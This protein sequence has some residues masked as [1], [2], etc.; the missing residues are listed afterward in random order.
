MSAGRRRQVRAT[1]RRRRPEHKSRIDFEL[2]REIASRPTEWSDVPGAPVG[3]A[4]GTTLKERILCSLDPVIMRFASADMFDIKGRGT[5]IE[6]SQQFWLDF[7]EVCCALSQSSTSSLSESQLRSV[8]KMF[9]KRFDD[10]DL[11]IGA[12]GYYLNR[13]TRVRFGGFLACAEILVGKVLW[14]E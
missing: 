5:I 10:I 13:K 1:T 3:V 14:V 7:R 2:R 8:R 12:D 6:V 4:V 11:R 9:E